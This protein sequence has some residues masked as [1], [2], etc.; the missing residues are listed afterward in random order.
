MATT[1]TYKG[2][3]LTTVDNATKVLET[4][5]TWMEDDLTL[6]DV[7]GGGSGSDFDDYMSGVDIAINSNITYLKS[8][9]ITSN[10]IT[11]IVLPECLEFDHCAVNP[12]VHYLNGGGESFSK[13][14]KISLPKLKKCSGRIINGVQ[15]STDLALVLPSLEEW[16]TASNARQFDNSARLTKFDFGKPSITSFDWGSGVAFYRCSNVTDVILRYGGVVTI[17]SANVFRKDNSN[18]LP[19]G[20]STFIYVPSSLLASYKTASNWS[21]LFATY[22]DMFKTIEGSY[23]ETHYAD[24]T[25]I[26]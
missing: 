23:Y 6:V 2:A 17:G 1:V 25:V 21:S 12:A 20:T 18:N 3:T 14:T 19:L 5:G 8:E 26:S 22:P 16:A 24:G 9:G 11:E 7:S 15:G 10:N 13:L 4:A